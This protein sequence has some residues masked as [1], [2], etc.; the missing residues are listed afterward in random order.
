MSDISPAMKPTLLIVDDA[1]ENIDVLKGLLHEQYLLRP[2]ISGELALRLA[3]VEP[4]PS[5]I[6][7]DVMMPVMDGYEVCR[8][9]KGDPQTRDIPV[10]FITAK[11]E[12]EDEVHGLTLGAVDYLTK[13]V[14]PAIVKA[15]VATHLALRQLRNEL[16]EKNLIL[17]DEKEFLEEIVTRMQ[18]SSPFDGRNVRFIQRA[19]EQ[20]AGDIA[21]SACRPDG[22]QHVLVGDFSGH[23]LPAALGGPLVSYIF[24]RLTSEGHDMQYILA[25]VNRTLCRQ[26]PTQL[27]MAASALEFSAQDKQVLAWNNGL[28]PLLCLSSTAKMLRLK[29]SGLP[30]GMIESPE[31]YEPHA[32]LGVLPDMRI[33][34]YSDGITEAETSAHEMYGQE[35]LEKMLARIYSE[36]LPLE[37]LWEDLDQYCAGHGLTDDALLMETI[38]APWFSIQS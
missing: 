22:A 12:T 38:V 5:L 28:P 19:L 14:V 27:Y 21:L 32:R 2:A 26:L 37:V 35:R 13:P 9:L 29:S 10:I 24:Y 18:A 23:G 34:Q 17:S 31:S 16:E 1:P 36:K 3:L 25:E 6:L 7:L 20:T 8:R 30:L 15:R 4:V 33:Y 11:T